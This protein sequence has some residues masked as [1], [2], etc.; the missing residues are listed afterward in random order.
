MDIPQMLCL[1]N[2]D[3]EDDDFDIN[4]EEIEWSYSSLQSLALVTDYDGDIS[5]FVDVGGSENNYIKSRSGT[6]LKI[7]KLGCKTYNELVVAL[8]INDLWHGPTVP[9]DSFKAK[10]KN[11]VSLA[12]VKKLQNENTM[13]K[14]KITEMKKLL[15]G[16]SIS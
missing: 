15:I 7:S 16:I 5:I 6:I 11:N 4:D 2:V 12:L 13:L 9:V 10:S 3:D 8:D 1:A 14:K